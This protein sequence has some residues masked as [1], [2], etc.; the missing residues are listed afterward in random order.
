MCPGRAGYWVEVGES[1]GGEENEVRRERE[2]EQEGKER[3]GEEEARNMRGRRRGRRCERGQARGGDKR[4]KA[5]GE[6]AARRLAGCMQ[7][8]HEMANAPPPRHVGEVVVFAECRLQLQ[9]ELV[10]PCRPP[11]LLFILRRLERL[12]VFGRGR[13]R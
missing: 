1:H 2:R 12:V 13:L 9:A 8:A 3:G 11:L 10:V 7:I 6:E 4:G 5:R